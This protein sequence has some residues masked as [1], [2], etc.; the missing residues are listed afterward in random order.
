MSETNNSRS[1]VSRVA[2][3][4]VSSTFEEEIE[5]GERSRCE[6]DSNSEEVRLWKATRAERRAAAL[7][8]HE[9]IIKGPAI[10]YQIDQTLYAKAETRNAELTDE[11]RAPLQSRGDAV[12]KALAHPEMQARLDEVATQNREGMAEI[13]RHLDSHGV[14]WPKDIPRPSCRPAP[15]TLRSD[16]A[17][18][19]GDAV[20]N[21]NTT[22]QSQPQRRLH[23][24]RGYLEFRDKRLAALG[25]DQDSSLCND[26]QVEAEI[27]RLW[28]AMSEEEQGE[29][30]KKRRA[31]M[32]ERLKR[33]RAGRN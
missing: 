18:I 7:K 26:P 20:S 25:S 14:P 9:G 10:A 19:S 16:Q 31:H 17:S 28:S 32:M 27:H 4:P 30:D 6:V 3:I 22:N 24:S 5:R 33:S 15:S 29:W 8:A 2:D 12:G 11:E 23:L 21:A 1:G 13:E